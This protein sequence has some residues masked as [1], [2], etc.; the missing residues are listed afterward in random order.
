MSAERLSKIKALIKE[1]IQSKEVRSTFWKPLG[2]IARVSTSR[3]VQ[4]WLKTPGSLTARLKSQCPNLEV[5][6]L[7]EQFEVPLLSESQK[8]GLQY[9][10]EAWV[11]CVALK[12]QNHNWI[13][14]RTIIPDLNPQNPWQELKSLG[15]KPLGEVLFDMPSIKRSPFEFSKDTLAYWPY[16]MNHLNNQTLAY[17]PSFARRS[18]FKQNGAPLLLTEVFLPALTDHK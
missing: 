8:L 14:A 4:N 12:C 11:R 1:K 3:P 13:Y 18:V 2:L 6:V 16:L 5:V 10:E 9:N 17:K 15:N 7:S